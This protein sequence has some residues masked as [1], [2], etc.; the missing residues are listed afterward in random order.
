MAPFVEDGQCV[1]IE[2]MT[3]RFTVPK[4]GDIVVFRSI[5]TS[6]QCFIKRIVGMPGEHITLVGGDVFVDGNL[7]YEAYVIDKGHVT[8]GPR[9]VEEARYCVLGD[10]R[11]SSNDSL[12]WGML[13]VENIVGKVISRIPNR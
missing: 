13:P 4:R 8:W 11:R 1:L 2:G 3:Y 5:E 9:V 6:S 10:N 7:L 12:Y